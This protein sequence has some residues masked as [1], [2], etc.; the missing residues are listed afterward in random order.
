MGQSISYLGP[1]NRDILPDDYRPIQNLDT[2]RIKIKKWKPE[3][4]PCRLRKVCID[5]VGFL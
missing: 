4:F 5:R 2:F 3:N 1:K